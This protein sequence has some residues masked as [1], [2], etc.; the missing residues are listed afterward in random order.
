LATVSQGNFSC[1]VGSTVS[2]AGTFTMTALDAQL[3][4][5]H[6]TFSGKD[7]YCTYNGRFGGTR[8]ATG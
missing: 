6:A 2:N 7:Q 4:G 3:N 8:D 5:F 1:I